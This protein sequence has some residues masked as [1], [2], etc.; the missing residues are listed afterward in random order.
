MPTLTIRHVN[1]GETGAAKFQA[2]GEQGQAGDTAEIKPPVGFPVDGRPNS[3][4]HS[5]LKWYL[6]EFLNYPFSPE[7]EHAERVRAS[8]KAWGVQ[9][10]N[11][12]FENRLGALAFQA[13]TKDGLSKLTI[14]IASDD[15]AVLGWPWEALQDPLS[16]PLAQTCQLE[17]RL[18]H[19]LAPEA[20]KKWP[21]DRV[22][23][24]LVTARPYT[25][26][27]HYRSISRPLFELIEE[28]DLPAEVT[29]LRP[30]TFDALRD[31]LR[32]HPHH[33]HVLHFD[34]HGAYGPMGNPSDIYTLGGPEGC[35]VFEKEDGTEDA[36][37]SEKLSVL[38]REHHIPM[39]VLNAC[40][41]AMVDGR[42]DDPFNSV[43]AALVKAGIRSVV[44]MAYSLYV[45]G[46]Q[47]F[48]P[49]F[50]AGLFRTGDV[51]QAT[52]MGRQGM[53]A[54]K[55]RTCSRGKFPLE[56]WLVPVVYQNQPFDFSFAK[57]PK[58][59]KKK[60]EAPQQLP[61]PQ[62]ITDRKDNPFGF[63]GRDAAVLDLERAMRRRP[64]GLLIQGLGGVGKT[65]LAR[66]FV[67]WLRDSGGLG[68]GAFWITFQDVRSAESVFNQL[69]MPIFGHNF[70]AAGLKEK[71]QALTEAFRKN[72]YVI[73]WDNFEVVRGIE[74]TSVGANLTAEDQAA[75]RTFLEGL[76]GGK[77]KVLITSRGDESWLGENNRYEIKLRGLEG[78]ERWDLCTAILDDQGLTV[79]RDDPD[80]I[81]LMDL[82]AGHP[83]AMRVIVPRLRSEKPAALI[84][85]L[86]SNLAQLQPTGDATLDR[87]SATLR[88]AEQ[89]LPE[90]LR[91]ILIPLALHERFAQATLL[92]AMGQQIDPPFTRPQIDRALQA[93][94]RSGLI[95]LI[96]D[97]LYELH[98]A[99]TGFLRATYAPAKL[100]A[101]GEPWARAFVEIMGSYADHLA[102]R[103]LHEQRI[104]FYLHGASFHVALAEAERIG[105]IQPVLAVT[106]SLAM[107]AQHTLN[108][109]EANRL[110]ERLAQTSRQR[111]DTESEGI[112]YHQLGS[113]AQEQRDFQAARDW[114]LKSLDI[115]EKSGNLHHAASTYHQIGMIAQEQRD[116]LAARDWYIKSLDIKEKSG[117]LHGAAITYHQLGIIAQEQRDF[118]A[119]RDWYI[120][121]LDIKE[122]SGDLHGA[123]STY[124]Q[125]GIIA[126]EQRDFLAARDWYIKSLDIKEKSGNLHGAA[127]TYH[128]LGSIAQ[129]Q[130]DFLAARD[131]YI[132][133][134]DI[135][136]KSGNLHGAAIT[137][138]QLGSIAQEQRDFLA[139][140]DWYIKSLDIKEK[141]GDLH[142]AAMTYGALGLMARDQGDTQDARRWLQKAL[143]QFT[144][145]G[146]SYSAGIT[147]RHLDQL[148]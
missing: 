145:L 47:V 126:Q 98:P 22:N 25:Q 9:A 136:E 112:T 20:V 21:K 27:V 43:A 6:E 87:L 91:P 54:N 130:R 29:V 101:S 73:V 50:Y 72:P 106:Q 128:Q 10:Y 76:Y 18:N 93:L 78:E 8:L 49:D 26:D 96:G 35:L 74:G 105:M 34:G 46:A 67:K 113:I 2:S 1:A 15:P 64:A 36:V 137:Y 14:L 71:I 81:K 61:L 11:A 134:L 51:A 28:K 31:H 66:G 123:A 42:A 75:L 59:S 99:L 120:K 37:S 122:K 16:G 110:F 68:N 52:R 48:L 57:N 17:R 56:D 131:W 24:L 97:D 89:A 53:F 90:D 139:A 100:G 147:Q 111:Q 39:M 69:G 86:R 129:E 142:G 92:E 3:D 115:N 124:H 45:S 135:K 144:A 85:A 40:Q 41:S 63:I 133:S 80:L 127:I 109:A 104:P 77:T 55:N 84:Q 103:P 146:D 13:A 132:K 58:P 121:S 143:Q 148:P 116:F 82:L 95:H 38:L 30:P 102:P 60:A 33:Y 88:L 19:V 5:E 94:A 23:V 125:L 107:H 141:S 119:A 114:Y 44:A 79:D 4:L 65:T 70:G 12:L 62:E 140:R 108:F 117:N 118:L 138:H 83:L 7:T 32:D